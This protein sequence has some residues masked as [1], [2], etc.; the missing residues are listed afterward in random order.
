MGTFEL[1]QIS[2]QAQAHRQEGTGEWAF[3]LM[4]QTLTVKT[5]ATIVIIY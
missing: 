2:R 5:K 3:G 4:G 1:D